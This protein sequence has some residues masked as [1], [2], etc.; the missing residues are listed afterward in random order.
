MAAI[1]LGILLNEVR[2]ELG[3]RTIFG[4]PG[5]LRRSPAAIHIRRMH[6]SVKPNAG[7]GQPAE[8]PRIC[9]A[10]DVQQIQADQERQR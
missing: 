9:Y 7:S 2:A 4:I 6:Q 8:L 5:S 1:M 10:A 3:W